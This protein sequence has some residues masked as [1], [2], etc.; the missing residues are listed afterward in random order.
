MPQHQRPELRPFRQ[1]LQRG[2]RRFDPASPD[3][4]VRNVLPLAPVVRSLVWL[5]CLAWL[6]SAVDASEVSDVRFGRDIRP[7]LAEHCFACHGPDAEHREAGLRLDLRDAAIET[8]IDP[9]NASQSELLRRVTSTDPDVVMPPPDQGSPITDR[10]TQ[11]LAAWIDQGAP[12]ETHWAFR[13]ISDPQPPAVA[14]RT[15]IDRFII[16]RQRQLGIGYAPPATR[17]QLIRRA[18]YD[19]CGI[20]PTWDEVASFVNDTSPNAFAKVIDRLL[21]STA[22]GERW[23]RHWLD[24]ARYADTEGGAA[25]GFKRFAFSY[26]YR[27]YV[28]Q[29]LNQDL[30]FDDFIRQ[31]LAAD[32][33]GLEPNASELAALGFLTVGM[34][35]RSRHD[36]IDDQ[37]D[38]VSRGLMGLTVSCARC[39]DHK[40]DPI[41]TEDYYALYAAFASS[42]PPESLPRVAGPVNPDALAE[43]DVEL[44]RL[45][46]SHRDMARD[47]NAVM[48]SRLRMQVG[49]YLRE[50]AKGTGRHDTSVSFLS[51]RTDDIR[52]HILNRWIDYLADL[53]SNDPVF[54]PLV[55]TQ[56]FG[57]G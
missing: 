55:S 36:T 20:P 1:P 47:H 37:I 25:I 53:D 39:H 26:T 56:R 46:R 30:A 18:T 12:F 22:Y 14:G 45:R 34:Q 19:L 42:E 17:Q 24:I 51:Y 28:I 57:G 27:D 2:Q 48:R 9:G 4:I 21:D 15:P 11:L 49:L 43:Y 13:P 41:P 32:Q 33:L 40:F 3:R 8:A 29:A 52:P 5:G 50:I 6:A 38:A 44:D 23:A 7:I 10:E 16:A 35:F 54:G 31:Q